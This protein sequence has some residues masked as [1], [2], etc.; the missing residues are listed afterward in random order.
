MTRGK[1]RFKKTG[2]LKKLA[3]TNVNHGCDI[4]GSLSFYP[5]NDSKSCLDSVGAGGSGHLSP[6][7]YGLSPSTSAPGTYLI[8]APICFLELP[9]SPPRRNSPL[10]PAFSKAQQWSQKTM[11]I[12]AESIC[13]SQTCLPSSQVCS[14]HGMVPRGSKMLCPN[15][16]CDFLACSLQPAQ[17][18]FRSSLLCY[19][20]EKLVV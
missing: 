8:A 19:A 12:L 6:D 14:R 2:G 20:E 3:A 5:T 1:Q 10:L 9:S 15:N 16:L 18:R 7:I 11:H 4:P 17:P 13:A